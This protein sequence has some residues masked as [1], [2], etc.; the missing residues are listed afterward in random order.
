MS[1][2]F[3]FTFAAMYGCIYEIFLRIALGVLRL[4]SFFEPRIARWF[5]VR[6]HW[7][8]NLPDTQGKQ[9]FWMHV[10]SLGE[11]EQGRPVLDAFRAT[12]PDWFILLSFFSES[13]Y[14]VRSTYSAADAVIYLPAD[15][16]TQVQHFLSKVQPTVAVFI[17]YDFWY[18][19]LTALKQRQIPTL[20]V[21]AT[22]RK[23]QPFFK[24]YGG[25]W[26]EMLGCF[27]YLF[28]QDLES[29]DLLKTIG[30]NCEVIGDT[31]IDRV[32]ELAEKTTG[33]PLLAARTEKRCL[34]LGSI[35]HADA[36]ILEKYLNHPRYRVIAAPHTLEPAF[37]ESL[38][39]KLGTEAIRLS[40]LL[41][42]SAQ[43]ARKPLLV[44]TI[45]HLNQLYALADVAYIGGGFGSGIH[46][47]LE[48]AAYGIPILFG[49]NYAKFNE[50]RDLVALGGAFAVGDQNEL[51]TMLN[52]LEEAD[53]YTKAC[54]VVSNYIQSQKGATA[55][56]MEKIKTKIIGKT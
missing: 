27:D 43:D 41:S 47:I 33:R 40:E 12:Y 39:K 51:E 19:Y 23:A 7:K 32:I 31:R 22:F 24:W 52:Y 30:F 2:P 45:G 26:R 5:E 44:D 56:V 54:A 42:G 35:W 1:G 50:A 48:P 34:V 13:G 9:V 46:N 29:A 49:P 18:G 36:K 8:Q 15:T 4:V 17:K 16:R 55:L 14:S 53:A 38:K 6:K 20:L 21:S 3:L 25:F 37:L 11:F 28:V 10:S